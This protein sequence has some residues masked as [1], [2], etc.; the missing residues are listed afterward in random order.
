LEALYILDSYRLIIMVKPPLMP[1][2][3][4]QTVIEASPPNSRLQKLYR[5]T[6]H[7]PQSREHSNSQTHQASRLSS[8]ASIAPRVW[9]AMYP[10]QNAY[11]QDNV[12]TDAIN[13]GEP[14]FAEVAC[15]SWLINQPSGEVVNASHMAIY[16]M[17]HIMLHANVTLL[18][19]FAHPPSV[20][21]AR[22]PAKSSMVSKVSAYDVPA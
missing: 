7:I 14:G 5:A 19:T 12:L 6:Q 8:L 17:M 16:H 1:W 21:V 15:E 11:G 18:Q 20:S 13:I 2:T 4:L 9:A 3:A 22:D 10:R